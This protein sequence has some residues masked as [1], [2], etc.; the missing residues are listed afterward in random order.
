MLI[1][2]LER[3]KRDMTQ[4]ALS[5]ASGVGRTTITAFENSRMVPYQS[6]IDRIAR[7]LGW[8]DDPHILLKEVPK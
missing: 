3:R 6:Q 7:A 1:L 2:E 4:E 8:E 5:R